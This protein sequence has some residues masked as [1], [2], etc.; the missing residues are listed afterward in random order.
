[1]T[2]QN[3]ALPALVSAD[4]SR[5]RQL[6]RRLLRDKIALFMLVLLVV[7]VLAAVFAPFLTPFDP[8]R[9]SLRSRN[10]PPD[11]VHWLGTDEQGRDLVARVLFGIR[12]TLASGFTSL[13]LGGFTGTIIGVTAAY[14][15]RADNLLM[16][17]MDVLLSFPAILLGLAIAGIWGPGT[18]GI[19]FALAIS[20][21][22]PVARVARAAALGV[23]NQDY[24][25]AARALGLGDF[26]IL[27]RYVLRNCATSVLVYVTLRF[28]QVILLGA[29][30]SFLGLGAP[31]PSA[32]LGT[33]VSQGRSLLFTAPHV[34]LVPCFTLFLIVLVLNVLGDA[35]R[36][37]FDP[38]V[39][40]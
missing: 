3:V 9:T 35:A 16:R 1:M 38:K 8:Y 2:D 26:A 30:L 7:I 11:L 29:S 10:M 22:P 24:L 5:G 23:V 31:P 14:Y 32:E 18:W 39:Q 17:A 19:I 6:L 21:I 34:A 12:L 20:T 28:G 4:A 40:Q 25:V 33:M 37:I 27:H 15:K 13:F 36:D